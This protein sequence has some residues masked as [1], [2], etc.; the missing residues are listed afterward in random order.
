MPGAN[1]RANG[2]S[3]C[4]GGGQVSRTCKRS[5]CCA[6][7]L[8]CRT[9]LIGAGPHTRNSRR[10]LPVRRLPI[11]PSAATNCRPSRSRRRAR[12][13]APKP[14][15]YRRPRRAG[16]AETTPIPV[17]S[18]PCRSR[19][20][21]CSEPSQSQPRLPARNSTTGRS[22]GREKSSKRRPAS[23]SRSTA[24]KAKPTVF[25][26]GYNLDHGTDMAIWVDDM[27]THAALTPMGR[28][29]AI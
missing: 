10:R 1:V 12:S 4:C 19:T 28:A 5:D 3:R 17:S 27:P 2:Q 29:T 8:S 14:P 7:G 21:R 6:V 9:Q 16:T 26:R 24:A 23:S 11:M 20:S 22:R 25:L 15:R 13:R 18:A